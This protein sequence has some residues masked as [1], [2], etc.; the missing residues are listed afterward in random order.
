M[1][2]RHAWPAVLV[3]RGM[4]GPT[5]GHFHPVRAL[6][7]RLDARPLDTLA[8]SPL[9]DRGASRSGK[10]ALVGIRRSRTTHGPP[11]AAA[12]TADGSCFLIRSATAD[13]LPSLVLPIWALVSLRTKASNQATARSSHRALEILTKSFPPLRAPQMPATFLRSRG[14]EGLF[15]SHAS[16]WA[17]C[18]FQNARQPGVRF[19]QW[20]AGKCLSIRP[21]DHCPN[22]QLR[23]F[24]PV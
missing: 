17:D 21:Y 22:R 8:Q 20:D 14:G 2:F 12:I 19:V 18:P 24:P 5:M 6:H 15:A 23:G 10:G 16:T 1:Y 3:L 7:V 11:L 4:E 9:S 13:I